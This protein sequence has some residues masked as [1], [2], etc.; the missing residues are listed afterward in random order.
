MT[1][2]LACII[3]HILTIDPAEW[4]TFDASDRAQTVVQLEHKP[5]GERQGR[6]DVTRER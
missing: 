4:S 2:R 1:L 5:N 6:R 3:C